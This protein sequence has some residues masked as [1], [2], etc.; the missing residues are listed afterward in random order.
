MTFSARLSAS[1]AVVTQ[2]QCLLLYYAAYAIFHLKCKMFGYVNRR[3]HK[4]EE[5]PTAKS[6]ET[7][8]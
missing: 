1:M 6:P 7:R 8:P 2:V 5:I 3:C 4:Y